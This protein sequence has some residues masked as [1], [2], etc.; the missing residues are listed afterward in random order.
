MAALL[1][2]AAALAT[3]SASLTVPG[4][5]PVQAAFAPRGTD[6]PVYKMLQMNLRFNNT[7]PGKVLSLVGRTQ[8]DVIT[9]EEVSAMWADKLA[10]LFARYPHHMLCPHPG[11][12]FGVAHPVA[13]ALCRGRRAEVLRRR[14]AGDRHGRFRRRARATSPPFTSA[15]PGRSSNRDRSTC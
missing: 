1:F 15:G 4:I 7:E 6:R 14:V 9:F 8:P 2:G 12:L 13:P 11:K 10:P 3:T 5:G